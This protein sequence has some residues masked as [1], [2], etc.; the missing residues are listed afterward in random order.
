MT[1][2]SAKSWQA[3]L[4]KAADALTEQFV[5]SLSVDWRL[6]KYDIA[7]SVVHAKMLAR[8]GLI[9]RTE[10]GEIVRGLTS[11]GQDIDAG[12]L[13]ADISQ[14]DIHMV[15]EAALI[16]RIGEPGKKLH[17]GRSRNAQVALDMRRWMR[18]AI[19]LEMIPRLEAVQKALVTLAEAQGK[20][21]MPGYTHMQH[22]QP[23]L[24]GTYLLAYAEMLHRDRMRFEDL[25]RRVNV[26]PLGAGALAGS[27]LPLDRAFVATE[28]GFEAVAENSL[29]ATSDRDFCIEYIGACAMAMLHLSRLAEDWIIYNTQEFKFLRID[30]AFCTGSSMMPQKRNP[31]LLEL[32]RGRSGRA[33]GALSG[34][35]TLVKGQ[36]LCYNR[37]MQDD[38]THLFAAHDNAAMCLDVIAA[39]VANSRFDGDRMLAVVKQ[40]LTDATCLAEYLVTIR[41][42]F[43]QAH[44]I[45]G[46]LAAT[47]EARGCPLGELSLEDLRKEHPGIGEDVYEYLGPENVIHRYATEG[48]AGM[49]SLI[50]QLQRWRA[51]LA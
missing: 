47:C 32:V 42:P 49:R 17:T 38:K 34:I 21:I 7:G 13:K 9:S 23:I 11:I 8:V 36:P 10:L 16:A 30:D 51:R 2:K 45:V 14:E 39:I 22:A 41:V 12:R 15:V 50:T 25:R 19:D 26:C 48:S 29:D 44:Q 6:A 37:D 33:V 3:R 46:R 31:D 28:L 35:L 24:L 18:D 40:S 4:D 43:R 27:T 1:A 20:L 5:E